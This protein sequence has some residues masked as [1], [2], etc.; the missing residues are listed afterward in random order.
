M[1]KEAPK[2]NTHLP[3]HN[4]GLRL[5]HFTQVLCFAMVILLHFPTLSRGR[6]APDSIKRGMVKYDVEFHPLSQPEFDTP[7]LGDKP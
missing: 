4:P 1:N 2:E 7:R 3:R 6:K 5:F